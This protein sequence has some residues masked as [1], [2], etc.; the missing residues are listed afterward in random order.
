M[1]NAAVPDGT[2]RKLDMGVVRRGREF[3]EAAPRARSPAC[4]GQLRPN[5]LRTRR[6]R[7]AP[8]PDSRKRALNQ[9]ERRHDFDT[10]GPNS[11]QR[12]AQVGHAGEETV[13]IANAGANST[14][15]RAV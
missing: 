13:R 9:T 12:A 15:S 8:A 7:H 5:V 4:S 11:R 1:G 6:R 14:K 10:M 2:P 3:V